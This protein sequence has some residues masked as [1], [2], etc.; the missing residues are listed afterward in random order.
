MSDG[1]VERVA[2]FGAPLPAKK[3]GRWN[4]VRNVLIY[5]LLCFS[6]TFMDFLLIPAWSFLQIVAGRFVN[7]FNTN[8]W[9]LGLLYRSRWICLEYTVFFFVK[10][11]VIYQCYIRS[12]FCQLS[13]SW[14]G[15]NSTCSG[16][17]HRKCNAID[18]I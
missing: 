2:L 15:R 10:M 14:C 5:N 1:I 9:T 3:P 7:G 16:C 17:G 12:L 13:D 8:D 6:S 18:L 4:A 11:I